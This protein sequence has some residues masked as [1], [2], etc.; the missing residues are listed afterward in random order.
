[1]ELTATHKNKIAK[2][3]AMTAAHKAGH[4]EVVLMILNGQIGVRSRRSGEWPIRDYQRE[5]PSGTVAVVYVDYTDRKPEYYIMPADELREILNEHYHA[6]LDAHGGQRPR[7]PES[8]N[9][10]LRLGEIQHRH[11]AWTSWSGRPVLQTLAITP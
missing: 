5:V 9:V 11:D 4:P 3:D 8:G 2:F 1:M 6:H 10:G 7:S